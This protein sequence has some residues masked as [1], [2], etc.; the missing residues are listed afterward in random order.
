[1]ILSGEYNLK[2]IITLSWY[3]LISPIFMRVLVLPCS[4]HLYKK[5]QER[6]L[7]FSNMDPWRC[8]CCHVYLRSRSTVG[9]TRAKLTCLPEFTENN[10]WPPDPTS[11]YCSSFNRILFPVVKGEIQDFSYSEYIL[12]IYDRCTHPL[13]IKEKLLE[14]KYFRECGNMGEKRKLLKSSF[15]LFSRFFYSRTLKLWGYLIGWEIE[16]YLW[17]KVHSTFEYTFALN[18]WRS[19]LEVWP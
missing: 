6:A 5:V 14:I 4:C 3:F 8:G 15:S 18:I 19:W 12:S 16:N 7:L 13:E 10:W 9:G 11:S 2:Y 1:M 17:T